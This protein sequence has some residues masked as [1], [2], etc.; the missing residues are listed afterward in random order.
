MCAVVTE[1]EVSAVEVNEEIGE[2]EDTQKHG[3]GQEYN[4][5][6]VGLLRW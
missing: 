6:K 3:R 5:E 1:G 4:Q 2:D